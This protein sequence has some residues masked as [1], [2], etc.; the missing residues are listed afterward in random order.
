MKRNAYLEELGIQPDEITS[1]FNGDNDSREPIWKE[2]REKYG[3]DERETWCL[4]ST[5]VEW[6]YSHLMMYVECCCVDLTFH[7]FQFNQKTYTQKEAIDYILKCC[8]E[9][10]LC[11]ETQYD[12]ELRVINNMENAIKLLAVIFPAMWW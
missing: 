6:I 3:F 2:E 10:L 7:K 9:Y 12:E 4:R 5:L 1:N 8:K 11:D